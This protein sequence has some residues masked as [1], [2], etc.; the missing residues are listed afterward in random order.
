LLRNQQP[1]SSPAVQPPADQHTDM[2]TPAP[3]AT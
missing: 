1:F 2:L 3:R